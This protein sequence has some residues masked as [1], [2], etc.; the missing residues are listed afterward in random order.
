M[1]LSWSP[2]VTDQGSWPPSTE[3]G[4]RPDRKFRPGF[5]GAPA[6]AEGSENQQQVP[7]WAAP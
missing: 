4:Q 5:T 7:C 2:S 3:T 1:P 6:V